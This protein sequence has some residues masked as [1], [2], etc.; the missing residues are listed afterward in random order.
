MSKKHN[1]PLIQEISCDYFFYVT[2]FIGEGDK[3][4]ET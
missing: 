2:V 4:D 3:Y 1:S